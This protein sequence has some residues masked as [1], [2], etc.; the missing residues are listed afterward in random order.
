MSET[1]QTNTHNDL[2]E[3]RSERGGAT[4]AISLRVPPTLKASAEKAARNDHRSLSSLIEI[5]LVKYLE[6]AGYL[7]RI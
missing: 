4:V 2:Q 3:E 7:S 1:R 5:A 6:E